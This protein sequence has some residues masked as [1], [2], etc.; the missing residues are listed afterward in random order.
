MAEEV[1]LVA[2]SQGD[3]SFDQ[4]R[5]S[6]MDGC[7]GLCITPLRLDHDRLSLSQDQEDQDGTESRNYDH[8]RVDD[9]N[10]HD[11]CTRAEKSLNRN[12]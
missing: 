5:H 11:D 12:D 8:Y 9:A 10:Y 4:C 6:V 7:S 3:N 2:S 1:S